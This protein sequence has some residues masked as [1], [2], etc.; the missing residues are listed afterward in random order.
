MYDLL[1]GL[2]STSPGGRP[3]GALFFRDTVSGD[4]G[5]KIGIFQLYGI[6]VNPS[7]VYFGTK[8]LSRGPSF[9]PRDFVPPPGGEP[10]PL[11]FLVGLHLSDSPT[12]GDLDPANYREAAGRYRGDRA[13]SIWPGMHGGDASGAYIASQ[14]H[15]GSWLP[16]CRA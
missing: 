9:G 16:C 15:P 6:T 2:S 1:G 14:P 10:H 12:P 4:I 5:K 3:G 7:M 11:V 13:M 8:S